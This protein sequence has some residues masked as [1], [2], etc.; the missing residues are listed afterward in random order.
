MHRAG[1]YN[2]RPPTTVPEGTRTGEPALTPAMDHDGWAE[3][4]GAS[5]VAAPY[6]SASCRHCPSTTPLHYLHHRLSADALPRVELG[7]STKSSSSS[8]Y[9]PESRRH[10]PRPLLLSLLLQGSNRAPGAEAWPRDLKQVLR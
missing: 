4:R 10:H 1:I 6:L 2:R 9:I 8:L 7:A 3:L 5:S